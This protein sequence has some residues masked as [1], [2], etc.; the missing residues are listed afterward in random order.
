[1]TRPAWRAVTPD[2][3]G[4]AFLTRHPEAPCGARN[5]PERFDYP[6]TSRCPICRE[7]ERSKS[8]TRRTA[9][10]ARTNPKDANPR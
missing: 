5:S 8:P 9:H 10:P 3:V 1:M 6:M 4:H 2:G 7:E